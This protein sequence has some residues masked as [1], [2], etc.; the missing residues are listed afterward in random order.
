MVNY[1]AAKL[2]E[3]L[4]DKTPFKQFFMLINIE[5]KEKCFVHEDGI[6][7]NLGVSPQLYISHTRPSCT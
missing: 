1:K 2:L 3:D 4:L 5:R 7:H 6:F